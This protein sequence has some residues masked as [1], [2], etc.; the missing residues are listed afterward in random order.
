MTLLPPSKACRVLIL[1]NP[2]A[3]A[4][5]THNDVKRLA[6]LLVRQRFEVE[7]FTDLDLATRRANDLAGQGELRALVGVG[8]DGTA[9]ELVNRTQEGVALAL[10]PAGNE[11]LLARCFG[12]RAVPEQLAETIAGGTVI[13]LDAG[14]ANGR[15]FLLMASCGLDAEVVQTVH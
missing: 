7:V 10:Y 14:K 4:R 6:E 9:A 2:K 11:N 12:L 5:D 13:R 1:H 15:V 3:G 8:G